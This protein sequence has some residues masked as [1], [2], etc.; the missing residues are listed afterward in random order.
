MKTQGGEEFLENFRLKNPLWKI[1]H[2]E[3]VTIKFIH[4]KKAIMLSGF[5]WLGTASNGRFLRRR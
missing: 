5:S 2:T 1:S 3:E 4:G